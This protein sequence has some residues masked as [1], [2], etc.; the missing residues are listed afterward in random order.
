MPE[1][2]LEKATLEGCLH[3]VFEDFMRFNSSFMIS[4]QAELPRFR[5]SG[6]PHCPIHVAIDYT[7]PDIRVEQRSFMLDYMAEHGKL[8]HALMQK[9]LG[10]V[11]MMYGKWKCAKCGAVTPTPDSGVVGV[12]GPVYCCNQ[13]CDYVEYD[14]NVPEIGYTGHCDGLLMIRNKLLPIEMKVRKADVI[15]RIR[16]SGVYNIDNITQATSYRRCLPGQL[17]IPA[18]QFHDFVGLLYFDRADIRGRALVAFPYQAGIF[19]AEVR[20]RRRTEKIV[21][22]KR[23][24]YL[25][26]FCRNSQDRPYCPYHS[27]CFAPNAA[28]QLERFLPG[29]T[30]P[31]PE[32]IQTCPPSP[33]N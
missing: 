5:G 7:R 13:P 22:T 29:F 32:R 15:A 23:F 19:D 9:W 27:T 14:I 2:L 6:I 17:H 31:L 25:R 16:R 28:A 1:D 11:G 33:Q 21:E 24:N 18:E 8:V 10:I 30:E 4:E 26:G 12:L 3:G 20:S